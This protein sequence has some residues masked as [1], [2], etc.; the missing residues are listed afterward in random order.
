MLG[1]LRPHVGPATWIGAIP[2]Y[3]G[4]D[5][6]YRALFGGRDRF[7]GLQRVP[8]VRKTI[9]YGEYVWISG[10]RPQL[11]LAAL[12]S[13]L[14][15]QAARLVEMLLG[16]PT[17]PIGSYLGINLTTT[18]PTF[19][20]ARLYSAFGHHPL[21]QTFDRV[22]EFY[23]AWDDAASAT[24]LEL[25]AELRAISKAIPGGVPGLRDLQA[26]YGVSSVPALTR[27][28][29]SIRALRNRALPLR[30]VARGYRLDPHTPF[31]T[32]DIAFGLLAIRGIA[33]IVGVR[34]PMMDAILR[35]GQRCMGRRLLD[36]GGRIA[37]DEAH[38]FPER[39]GI[40]SATKLAYA[41]AN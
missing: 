40:D 17:A 36:Q 33:Q 20:P 10:I 1:D 16:I 9:S 38:P 37:G 35:W 13:A 23:E 29:R 25:D 21:D 3:G 41:A 31:F 24:F 18:N 15:P 14:A 5:W 6:R 12:P 30:A 4:I 26:H 39:F 32:E 19:H 22:E 2:G 34:V 27:V 7:F 28:I 11:F 8:Y